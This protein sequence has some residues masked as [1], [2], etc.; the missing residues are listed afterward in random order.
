MT[1]DIHEEFCQSRTSTLQKK[2]FT[3]LFT[4]F[5]NITGNYKRG[6]NDQ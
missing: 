4:C 3:E 2:G 1:R 5:E 6:F